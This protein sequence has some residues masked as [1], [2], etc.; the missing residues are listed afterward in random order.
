MKLPELQLGIYEKALS[1]AA[2]WP[3]RFEMAERLGFRFIEMSIDETDERLSRLNWSRKKRREFYCS[4]FDSG[5]AVSSICLSAHRRFPLGSRDKKTRQTALLIMQQ[6]VELAL[7]LGVRVIQIAGYDV[8]YEKSDSLTNKLFL[9]NFALCEDMANKYQINL[10]FEIMDT[11][12]LSSVKRFLEMKKIFTSCWIG[13]YPDIGN[14]SAWGNDIEQELF[15]GIDWITGIHVKDTL[16]VTDDFAGKFKEV[17][18]GTG[19]VDF[20]GFFQILKDLEYNRPLLIEMWAE[21]SINPER[22]AART[23]D[24]IL[25]HMRKA[26]YITD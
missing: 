6:A 11:L 14:L 8:Y 10:A 3:Q 7:D 16:A 19:C 13:L 5:I 12:Y 21:K 20:T 23:R 2:T 17:P 15:A 4:S 25:Q 1:S 9:E 26:G 22:E 24:F 18:F